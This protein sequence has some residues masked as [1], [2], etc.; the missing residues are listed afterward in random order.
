VESAAI[1]IQAKQLAAQMAQIETNM[2]INSRSGGP[3]G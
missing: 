2:F 3:D 1:L